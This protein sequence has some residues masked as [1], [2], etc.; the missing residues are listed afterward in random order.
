MSAK[1]NSLTQSIQRNNLVATLDL[2]SRYWLS[3][4]TWRR[5][6]DQY[7]KWEKN[8]AQNKFS[9]REVAAEWFFSCNVISFCPRIIFAECLL[10][11]VL[12]HIL[13]AFLLWFGVEFGNTLHMLYLSCFLAILKASL[14]LHKMHW[15]RI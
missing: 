12:L 15:Y 5:R 14:L 1:C 2:A 13:W 10:C 6:Q 11:S 4:F 7:I 9:Y 3:S 8:S